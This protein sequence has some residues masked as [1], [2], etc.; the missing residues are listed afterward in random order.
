MNRAIRPFKESARPERALLHPAWLAALALLVVNDHL[1]K[2]ADVLPGALTGKLS[3]VA[4]LFVAP[5]LLA[6]LLRARG[7]AGLVACHLAVG[8]GFAAIQLSAVM[9]SAWSDATALVGMRWT[10]WSDPT[11]LLALPAL[12][13]SYALLVPAMRAPFASRGRRAVAFGLAGVGLLCCLATSPPDGPR[14]GYMPIEADVYIHNSTGHD[15][16]VRLYELR[17]D[18]ALDCFEVA[19]DP[20][21]LLSRPLFDDANT[22]WMPPDTNIPAW[23]RGSTGTSGDVRDCYA[24]YV[25]IDGLAPAV[26][27]WRHG[28]PPIRTIPGQTTGESESAG[29]V[30]I[31]RDQNV[32]SYDPIGLDSLTILEGGI[33]VEVPSECEPQEDVDRVAW[34]TPLPSD[35]KQLIEAWDSGPDGCLGVSLRRVGTENTRRWYVCIPEASWP[36]SAGDEIYIQD[37]PLGDSGHGPLAGE[38]EGFTIELMASGPVPGPDFLSPLGSEC[39]VP[40]ECETNLCATDPDLALDYCARECD[41]L[42]P[43]DCSEEGFSCKGL[44]DQST[45]CLPTGAGLFEDACTAAA[46]C[47]STVCVDTSEDAA[48]CSQYCSPANVW[49]CPADS[50]CW[51]SE[52]PDVHMCVPGS[53]EPQETV[54]LTVSRQ[55]GMPG[56]AELVAILRPLAQCE[57]MPEESCGTVSLSSR[58]QLGNDD[59][60]ELDLRAG[61]SGTL[62]LSDDRTIDFHVVRATVRSVINT[63]CSQGPAEVG[64]DVEVVSIHGSS[65]T[66]LPAP[67]Q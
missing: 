52:Q 20:G 29:A 44:A 38:F 9:A 36:F 10:I 31:E 42:V 53:E 67:R 4:G 6:T 13:A 45:A 40:A 63:G 41:P 60:D 35:G 66:P 54:L 62:P 32:L 34:S 28:T 25:E 19:T 27:F 46:D 11:D 55:H 65:I 23:Y 3:D 15:L 26:L 17:P 48:I 61:E 12:A 30:I 64:N 47:A 1:L 5:V 57:P 14:E 50:V 33:S 2:A 24:V 59:G 58:L 7:R 22:W 49:S 16:I 43:E 51:P 37:I 18:V 8:I 21:L 56:P 39:T